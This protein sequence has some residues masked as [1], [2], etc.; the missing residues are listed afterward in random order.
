MKQLFRK[1]MAIG[2]VAVLLLSVGLLGA[3]DNGDLLSTPNNFTIIGANLFWTVDNQAEESEVYIKR[4]SEEIFSRVASRL[5]E[6]DGT[7]SNIPIYR[8]GL[9]LGENIIKV[10]SR[11]IDESGLGVI[12]SNAGYFAINIESVDYRQSEKPEYVSIMGDSLLVWRMRNDN[13]QFLSAGQLNILVE[14]E[15]AFI[16]ITSYIFPDESLSMLWLTNNLKYGLNNLKVYVTSEG[17]I[18]QNGTL[19]TLTNS[20]PLYFQLYKRA[21]DDYTII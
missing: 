4:N 8:L 12:S 21:L 19:Y 3:C 20:E 5:L 2:I 7:A 17:Q 1:I 14:R 10:V 16:D 15:G 6:I 9:E 13:F 11:A 18:I